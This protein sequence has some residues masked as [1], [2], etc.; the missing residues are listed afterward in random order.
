MIQFDNAVKRFGNI[1]LNDFTEDNIIGWVAG[2][3]V[4][5]H[6]L[7]KGLSTDVDL[8]FP[9]KKEFNKAYRLLIDEFG[10][11]VVWD[12]DNG[13][14]IKTPKYTFDLVK[15]YFE[16]PQK[17]I[18]AFD[19]TVSMFAVNSERVFFGETS[20]IDLAK[21][22]LMVNKIT[23]PAS[24]VKRAFRYYEKGFRMCQGE[25]KKLIEAVQASPTKPTSN[26]L[27]A[28]SIEADILGVWD[29][30]LKSFGISDIQGSSF[31]PFF[32]GID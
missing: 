32:N 12:S 26:T 3:S 21:Q 22:Q 27:S 13:C 6:F 5:D 28:S 16:D 31:D 4:R 17:T 23:Y 11:K 20:F 18:E 24:S 8:F 29:I 1:I 30:Q 2:G 19:F 25:M 15:K 10:G 14:K 9:N 7:G